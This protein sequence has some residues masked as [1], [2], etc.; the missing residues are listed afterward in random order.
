MGTPGILA[1]M[2]GILHGVAGP[3][4]V[5]GVIPAVQLR[6]AKLAFVYLST[7][8]LTSTLVMGCFSMFYG[9]FSEW[10]AGGRR[11]GGG[12]SSSRVFVV[13]VGSAF[14]S[15]AVGIVWLVLLSIGKLEDIF[16]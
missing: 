6:N 4:G 9:R 7:F 12:G 16:P 13:E 10:L 8:C 2:A 11:G 14:L 5:L 3:G 1:I 15:I